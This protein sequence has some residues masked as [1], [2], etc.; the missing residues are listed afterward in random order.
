MSGRDRLQRLIESRQ[1]SVEAADDD[2]SPEKA[3][4]QRSFRLAKTDITR[5]FP[6]LDDA[7]D[8]EDWRK[9][10]SEM[11]PLLG[12]LASLLRSFGVDASDLAKLQQR[13]MNQGYKHRKK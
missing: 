1:F 3:D 11:F 10:A 13:T 8:D 5:A 2:E 6:K 9:F 7:I 4:M 12:R